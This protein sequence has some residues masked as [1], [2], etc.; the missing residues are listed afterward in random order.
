MKDII[1]PFFEEGDFKQAAAR[2]LDI[3]DVQPQ[4]LL[5]LIEVFGRDGNLEVSALLRFYFV[6]VLVG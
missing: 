3:A 2:P 4:D 6:T 5:V 1:R